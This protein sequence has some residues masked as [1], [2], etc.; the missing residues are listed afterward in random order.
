MPSD[1]IPTKEIHI[2]NM[3]TQCTYMICRNIYII[4]LTLNLLMNQTQNPY[5]RKRQ[6]RIIAEV[7]LTSHHQS[8]SPP[9]PFNQLS[10]CQT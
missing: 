10:L 9:K 1:A 6:S 2:V 5:S 8:D 3:T 4:W 7:L